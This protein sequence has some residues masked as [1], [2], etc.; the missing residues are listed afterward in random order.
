[1]GFYAPEQ[2]TTADFL[3]SLTS[4]LERRVREGFEGRTP[5]T[6]DEFAAAW[7][8]SQEY[9]DLMAEIDEYERE[10]P[11]GGEKA[12]AFSK[13]V[14]ASQAKGAREKSPFMLT[15]GQQVGLCLVCSRLSL[16]SMC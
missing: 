16:R 2:Q 14:R 3:T 4:D 11:I 5:K 8:R 10:N 13:A 9:R 12:Q 1:M 15:Y 6:P 7:Q